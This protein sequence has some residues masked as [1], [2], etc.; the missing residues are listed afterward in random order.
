MI[1]MHRWTI[2]FK[3]LECPAD[4]AFIIR[5]LGSVQDVDDFWEFPDAIEVLA[6][7]HAR[8]DVFCL[9]GWR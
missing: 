3:P 6:S 1:I 5:R 8:S 9:P 2:L 4:A 7:E